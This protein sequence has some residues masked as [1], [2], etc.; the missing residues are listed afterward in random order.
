MHPYYCGQR[1]LLNC[2]LIL[3]FYDYQTSRTRISNCSPRS[4]TGYIEYLEIGSCRY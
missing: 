3:R 2:Y 1:K 4:I